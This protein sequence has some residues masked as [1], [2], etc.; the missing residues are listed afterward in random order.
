MG[1]WAVGGGKLDYQVGEVMPTFYNEIAGGAFSDITSF[2]D[3]VWDPAI[4]LNRPFFGMLNAMDT[5][6][7]VSSKFCRVETALGVL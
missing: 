3:R 4:E 5:H 7:L 1:Y 2:Q 6:Q